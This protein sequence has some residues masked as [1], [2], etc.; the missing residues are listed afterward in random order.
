MNKVEDYK[1]KEQIEAEALG[2]GEGHPPYFKCVFLVC[3]ARDRKTGGVQEVSFQTTNLDGALKK[4]KAEM[5]VEHIATRK[6]V[7]A[8]CRELVEN[9]NQQRLGEE[10]AHFVTQAL[11]QQEQKAKQIIENFLGNGGA[12]REGGGL[13]P[14]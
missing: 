12:G 4:I 13:H 10:V 9:F 5:E 2:Y 6:D 11:E 7:L 8:A 14:D 3:V 1:D